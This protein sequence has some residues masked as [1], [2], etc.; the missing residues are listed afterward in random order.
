[1]ARKF[2][3]LN[4]KRRLPVAELPRLYLLLPRPGVGHAHP[5]FHKAPTPASVR[6]RAAQADSGREGRGPS[7]GQDVS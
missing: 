1:M 4:L 6:P 7:H 5:A 3:T 2:H